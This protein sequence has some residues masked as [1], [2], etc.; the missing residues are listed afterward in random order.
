MMRDFKTTVLIST[1]SHA[2]NIA[3]SLGEAQ[4]HPE[5]LNLRLG[6]L[7]RGAVE[8]FAQ[9]ASGGT[10]PHRLDRH[11]RPDGSHGA[12]RRRRVPPAPRAPHQRGPF[13]RRGHR[14]QDARPRR[15]RRGR[16]AGL[17]DDHQGRLPAHPL[18]DRRHHLADYRTLSVRPDVRTNGSGH[19]GGRT[20]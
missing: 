6:H 18:P 3:G 1:P 20:I 9:P 12:G 10:S 14:S 2:L 16:R 13:H 7:R 8:R 17:H 15:R 5:R 4:V 19:S 11:L